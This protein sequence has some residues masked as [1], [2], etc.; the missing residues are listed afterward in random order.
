M[1]NNQPPPTYQE[2]H[3][4]IIFD[5]KM[6]DF[7]RK[8]RFVAGGHIADTPHEITYASVVLRE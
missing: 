2:I 5:V 8:T 3:S 4:H 1:E 6:E 7:R